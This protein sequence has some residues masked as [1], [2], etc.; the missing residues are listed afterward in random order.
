ML[1][2]ANLSG[3]PE[4]EY[5]ADGIAEDLLTRLAMWR[6]CP[7]IARNSSFAYK[8]RNA[9]IRQVGRELGARYVLEGSVRK[10]GDRVRVTGQLVDAETGHHVWAD[11]YDR[12]L[13][14]IFAVQDEIV[15]SICGALEPAVGRAEREHAQLKPPASLQAWD[16]YLRGLWYLAQATRE[17][18]AQARKCLTSG[19][20]DR[21]R[22]RT[23]PGLACHGINHW[24]DVRLEW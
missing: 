4:Q 22:V 13:E 2:L 10:A 17:S 21:S 18:Y 20:R 16:L 23:T 12:K 7:V 19:D 5:F 24:N 1:P 15:D 6:W 3:D 14:D 11:R 9:D 8:G